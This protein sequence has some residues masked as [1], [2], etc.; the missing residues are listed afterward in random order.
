MQTQYRSNVNYLTSNCAI[1]YF[2]VIV[3]GIGIRTGANQSVISVIRWIT[4]TFF[5]NLVGP[6]V[7]SPSPGFVESRLSRDTK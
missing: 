1:N 7:V 3:I 4:G 6:I 5:L 2:Q